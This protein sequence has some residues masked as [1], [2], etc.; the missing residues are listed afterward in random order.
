MEILMIVEKLRRGLRGTVILARE[1]T[2]AALPAMV[3]LM[4]AG[5]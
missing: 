2:I 4:T 5:K 3:T 1:I